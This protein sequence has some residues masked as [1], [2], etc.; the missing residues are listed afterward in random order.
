MKFFDKYFGTAGGSIVLV[1]LLFVLFL[2]VSFFLTAGIL[3]CINWA[4]GLNFWSWK[5]CL[6]IWLAISLLESIFK[7]NIKIER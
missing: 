6:G 2:A 4:F 3:W 1:I 7:A 5:I